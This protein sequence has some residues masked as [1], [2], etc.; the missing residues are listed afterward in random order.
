MARVLVSSLRIRIM[1]AL[2]VGPMSPRMIQEWLGDDEYEISTID[3]NL[4][5]LERHG[6][7]ELVDVKTGG[8]RRGAT[9]HVYRA[10][11]LPIFDDVA[12]PALPL[13][14]REMVTWRAFE[15][16]VKHL[17]DAWG[18]GTLDARDDH[19]FTCTPGFVDQLGWDRIVARIDDLFALFLKELQDAGLRLA[20]S[21]EQPMPILV[22]LAFFE[23]PP[24][25]LIP[26]H[27]HDR[28]IEANAT[29]SKH[30]FS[31]RMAKVMIAPLR[32]VILEELS[33]R[34]MSAKM[35]F[36]E[37]GGRK[38]DELG[39]RKITENEVYRAFW[40][41]KKFDWLVLVDTKARRTGPG[42]KEHFY[43][44]VRPPFLDRTT[45]PVLPEST[46]AKPT[47]KTLETLVSRT[48]EAMEAGTMDARKD[49]HFTWTP[50]SLDG[51]GWSHVTG[52]VDDFLDFVRAELKGAKRR[53]KDSGERPIPI[54]TSLVAIEL[55]MG[56][57]R[58]EPGPPFV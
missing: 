13:A 39:G 37:F 34:A 6:W 26:D 18:A 44:A 35:F 54:T 9:E 25:R 1:V 47:G 40:T 43:R 45:W 50:G 48:R 2:S 53:L 27:D 16:L 56:S 58:V 55:T 7:V 20:D 21:G 12:W 49:R 24:G 10:I 31:L 23:S 38:I 36:E 19:H 3:K 17:K 33:T 14:M 46:K 30:V 42:G 8:A 5:E 41:L 22:A 15:T 11:R 57:T 29:L 28:L 51:L 32:L 4:K 52:E